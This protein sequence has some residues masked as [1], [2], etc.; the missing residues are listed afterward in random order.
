MNESH[1]LASLADELLEEFGQNE[2]AD[3][4]VLARAE[5]DASAGQ[6]FE[7]D[8]FYDA[9]VM[10]FLE[11][12]LI[13]R[14]L[15]G[16]DGPPVVMAY[17]RE[18]DPDRKKAIK[19]WATSHRSLFEVR[20]FAEG[21][22]ALFDLLGGGH[23]EVDERRQVHGVS[24]GDIVEARVIGSAGQVLFGRTFLYHPAGT[25]DAIL[26]HNRRIR[27]NGG[28]RA[29]VMSHIA[30]LRIRVERYAHVSPRQI[31]E[32]TTEEFVPERSIVSK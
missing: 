21:K 18:Q 5:Y 13:E 22:V 19:A 9:R 20:G 1:P 11:W 14:P 2:F 24:E 10:A 23:F 12:Y 27:D 31:Y 15:P 17:R 32:S 26:S 29:D 7:D 8:D 30:N 6:V 3:E 28:S 16:R 4:V 25:R